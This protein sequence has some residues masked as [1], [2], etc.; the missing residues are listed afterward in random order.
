MQNKKH[1]PRTQITTCDLTGLHYHQYIVYMNVFR[2]IGPCYWEHRQCRHLETS[3][4]DCKKSRINQQPCKC[5]QIFLECYFWIDFMSNKRLMVYCANTSFSALIVFQS[6]PKITTYCNISSIK[7]THRYDMFK[8]RN[9]LQ[10]R[11]ER[12]FSLRFL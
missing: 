6:K 8:L 7:E 1:S 3:N 10:E 11:L 9:V 2:F 12:L 4:I 5:N